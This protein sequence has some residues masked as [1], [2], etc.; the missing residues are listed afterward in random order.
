MLSVPRA[1]TSLRLL[2]FFRR[3]TTIL[4]WSTTQV[5]TVFFSSW[6]QFSS[7]DLLLPESHGQVMPP[8]AT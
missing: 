2:H 6:F 4:E 3:L 7:Q 1:F 8:I 5:V